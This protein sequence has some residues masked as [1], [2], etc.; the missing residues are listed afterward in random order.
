[1]KILLLRVKVFLKWLLPDWIFEKV[2]HAVFWPLLVVILYRYPSRRIKVIGVTG[3]NGKTTVVHLATHILENAGFKVAS[4]SSLRFKIDHLEWKNTLKMTMPGRLKMQKFLRQSINAR[5]DYVVM[6]VTSEG[7]KQNRHRFINF[8]TVVFTNLTPEHIESHGSLERYKETKG[9]LFA[10]PHLTSII[11]IDDENAGYFLNF[12]AENKITY[13]IDEGTQDIDAVLAEEIELGKNGISFQV[14][15]V[16]FDVP[17]LGRF[18][19]Y[20]TLTAVCIGLSQKLKLEDISKHLKTFTGVPGRME[21]VIGEPFVVIVD[22]AHTPDAMKQV[23]KTIKGQMLDVKGGRMLCVFGATGGGRDKWKRPEFAR[24][25]QN[26][27]DE[28]ILTNEDPYDEN[29]EIILDDIAKGFSKVSSF[30]FQVSRVLD[31]RKAINKALQIAKN[32]DFVVV[33]GKGAE[34]IM[35]SKEGAKKW[36]DRNIVREEFTKLYF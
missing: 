1:M 10:L 24:I 8:D 25:A 33:T 20:N 21:R 5:C 22:Y 35:M 15:G 14:D 31:R 13:S 26:Y 34:P 32:G 2:Y 30:K 16:Q 7:I 12:A 3:T 29:P 28:I 19:I 11:N 17:M 18:N 4:L 23:Y 9:K 36:D 27:C 6:E